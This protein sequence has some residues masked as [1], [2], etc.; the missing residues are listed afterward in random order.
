MHKA[1]IFGLRF[2]SLFWISASL[3]EVFIPCIK[4]YL[5]STYTLYQLCL[6]C[7]QFS[8]AGLATLLER[9]NYEFFKVN[10]KKYFYYF[11]CSI[12]ALMLVKVCVMYPLRISHYLWWI[13]V[14]DLGSS[15]IYCCRKILTFDIKEIAPYTLSSLMDIHQT[16]IRIRSLAV[17]TGSH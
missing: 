3:Y 11:W 7:S 6:T 13:N 5:V 1:C 15:G 10:K 16:R 2:K 14:L 8:G 9:A 12:H 17:L 4:A